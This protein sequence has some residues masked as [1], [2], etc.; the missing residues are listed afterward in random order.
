MMSGAKKTV[1]DTDHSKFELFCLQYKNI[2]SNPD[3]C[4]F[5]FVFTLGLKVTFGSM[6]YRAK[7]LS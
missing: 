4:L 6:L 1:F 7:L 3:I 5:P 2:P